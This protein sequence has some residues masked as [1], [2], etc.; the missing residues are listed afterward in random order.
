MTTP[1]TCTMI[2]PSRIKDVLPKVLPW[3]E[4][5]LSERGYANWTLEGLVDDLQ[6]GRKQLWG[7]HQEGHYLFAVTQVWTELTGPHVDICLAGGSLDPEY[8]ILN[9]LV[10]IEQWAKNINAKSMTISGRKGWEKLLIPY[11]YRFD[12]TVYR[13]TFTERFN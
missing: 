12:Y 7:A 11:G 13:H 10:V 5:T 8:A 1:N 2:P 9:H 4:K 6:A 3:L